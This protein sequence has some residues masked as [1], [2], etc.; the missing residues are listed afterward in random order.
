M[1]GVNAGLRPLLRM[2]VPR[3]LR[4]ASIAVLTDSL[5]FTLRRPLSRVPG[6]EVLAARI[7]GA[8][9]AHRHRRLVAMHGA[10]DSR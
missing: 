9:F 6:A 7:V 1:E 8:L 10:G 4:G 3:D 2:T 5:T